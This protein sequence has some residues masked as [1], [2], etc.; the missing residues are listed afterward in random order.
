MDLSLS[1]SEYK[2]RHYQCL[3]AVKLF[4]TKYPEINALRD[5]TE[6]ILLEQWDD[7]PGLLARRG[8]HVVTENN[9]VLES[10]KLLDEGDMFGF[11]ELMY[12]SHD[13][14][15][16]DYEVS[17]KHLDLLVDYTMDLDGVLGARLTGAG[18][19]GCT[20]NLVETDYVEEFTKT[21]SERYFNRTAKR[22]E[23]YLA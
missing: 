10:I 20:V 5:V 17:S 9:R 1:D 8:R 15:R 18:F 3:D 19:G 13:S 22:C 16:H 21:I 6:E 11:G 2:I 14:L 7:L 4:K 12:D 23:I